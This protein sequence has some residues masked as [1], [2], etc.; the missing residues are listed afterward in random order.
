MF[1]DFKVMFIQL[2]EAT[3]YTV[4]VPNHVAWITFISSPSQ[5]LKG[6]FI[7]TYNIICHDEAT[8]QSF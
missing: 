4:H 1:H 3:N 2:N 6:G 8:L 5:S 7:M